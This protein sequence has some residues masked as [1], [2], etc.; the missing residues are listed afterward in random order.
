V[1]LQE[2]M[3]FDPFTGNP[4]GSGRSV[5][6][7]HGQLNLIPTSRLNPAMM[8]LLQLAPNPNQAGDLNN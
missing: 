1:P 5:F 4:D 7:N 2:G 6:S 3:I 8:K